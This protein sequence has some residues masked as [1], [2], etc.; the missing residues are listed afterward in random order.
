MRSFWPGPLTLVLPAS[1]KVVPEEARAGL[2]TVGVR[3]PDHPLIMALLQEVGPVVATSV[4]L[5]GEPAATS[6]EDIERNFG[7]DFPVLDSGPST[8]GQE[9]T[10]VAWTKSGWKILR[11]GAISAEEMNLL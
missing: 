3:M 5:S 2:L 7:K 9:S 10:V 11:E 1:E 8:I 6:A 4:N